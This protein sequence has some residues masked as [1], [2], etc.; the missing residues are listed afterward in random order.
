VWLNGETVLPVFENM[1]LRYDVDVSAQLLYGEGQ[2]NVLRVVFQSPVLYAAKQAN[3]SEVVIP[4]DCPPPEQHG[5]CHS[6]FILKTASSFSWDWGP[7]FASIGIYKDIFLCVQ[8]EEG[9]DAQIDSVSV[10]V[11]PV[12]EQTHA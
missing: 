1:F 12:N 7:A 3:A 5:F 6:N 8:E 10:D 9:S 11:Y 2:V 4:P